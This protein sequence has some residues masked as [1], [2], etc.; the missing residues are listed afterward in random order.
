MKA[1]SRAPPVVLARAATYAALFIGFV[2]VFLPSRVLSSSGIS[3]PA[4]LGVPQVAGLAVC[5]AGAVLAAWCVATL[6]IVGRERLP[7]STRRAGSSYGVPT[8]SCAIRCM[9]VRFWPWRARRFII[10]R[11]HC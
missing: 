3:R 1:T 10:D 6:A 9:G 11:H 2:L 5:A 4:A 7:P 8:E